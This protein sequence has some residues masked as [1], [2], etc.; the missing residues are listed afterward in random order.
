MIMTSMTTMMVL[1]TTTIMMMMTMTMTMTMTMMTIMTMT[2]MMMK[3]KSRPGRECGG[4]RKLEGRSHRPLNEIHIHHSAQHSSAYSP[5]L[6][7]FTLTFIYAT[8]DLCQPSLP[9]HSA[10]RTHLPLQRHSIFINIQHYASD[11]SRQCPR[12]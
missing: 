10:E 5:T 8:K 12:S 1:L 9:F 7:I 3:A 11:C 2:I 6:L 4:G